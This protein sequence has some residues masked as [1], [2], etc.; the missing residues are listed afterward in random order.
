MRWFDQSC[1]PHAGIDGPVPGV[2][3]HESVHDGFRETVAFVEVLQQSVLQFSPPTGR[4]RMPAPYV[5]DVDACLA[6]A[7]ALR[8]GDQLVVY[9]RMPGSDRM[10][11]AWAVFIAFSSDSRGGASR[12]T[13]LYRYVDKCGVPTAP[14]CFVPSS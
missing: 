6:A 11:V 8:T 7:A 2:L 5:M 13:M 3:V 1:P 9:F 14:P 10:R 12:Q 4:R